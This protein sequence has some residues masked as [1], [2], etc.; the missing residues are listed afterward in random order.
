MTTPPNNVS[1]GESEA[2]GSED[3]PQEELQTLHQLV[4]KVLQSDQV[5]HTLN[6][7]SWAA[8]PATCQGWNIFVAVSD[9]YFSSSPHLSSVSRASW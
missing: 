1:E 2:P 9:S 7:G 3:A 6:K 8:M 5:E 4:P